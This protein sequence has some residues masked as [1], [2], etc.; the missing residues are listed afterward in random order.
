LNHNLKKQGGIEFKR[1]DS[2]A[3]SGDALADM[4][5]CFVDKGYDIRFGAKGNS[6]FPA[7]KDG[8]IIS[9]SP[10][11]GTRPQEGDIIAFIEKR[12]QRLFV[13]R[14]LHLNKGTFKAK[15][16]NC[17][18]SDPEQSRETIL[19]YVCEINNCPNFF[20]NIHNIKIK[21]YMVLLSR[22]GITAIFGR[23]LNKM[24]KFLSIF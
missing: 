15:G 20:G 19:G 5:Q 6:M 17:F 22:L 12:S 18:H 2:I 13:H 4:V 16:D 14:L 11:S 1:L 3:I 8:D 21:R 7:I 23:I 24:R 9:I 10:Y